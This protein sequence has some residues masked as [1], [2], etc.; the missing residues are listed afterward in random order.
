MLITISVITHT[1]MSRSGAADDYHVGCHKIF[2][3]GEG[4]WKSA[5]YMKHFEAHNDHSC[6]VNI[7][8]HLQYLYCAVK[9]V[10]NQRGLGRLAS[11]WPAST[12]MQFT[13]EIIAAW[14]SYD[15][16]QWNDCV[17]ALHAPGAWAH[18]LAWGTKCPCM[19]PCTH[20]EPSVP[21]CTLALGS[22]NAIKDW[23]A[24]R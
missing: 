18:T 14:I 20:G 15:E 23:S 21:V 8:I 7:L 10:I 16:Y 6:N 13:T 9:V 19:Q 12:C 22:C 24:A 1:R 17:A 3:G 11:V 5:L 2:K 4:C